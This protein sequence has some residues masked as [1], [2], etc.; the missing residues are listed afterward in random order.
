[1]HKK[2]A[3]FDFHYLFH[4]PGYQFHFFSF[5]YLV[6]CF[7]VFP[8]YVYWG[9][10]YCHINL[11]CLICCSSYFVNKTELYPPFV[12]VGEI[13]SYIVWTRF[14][15]TFLRKTPVPR[16]NMPHVFHCFSLL[17]WFNF[18]FCVFLWHFSFLNFLTVR[19]FF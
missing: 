15:L 8:V 19:R 2:K 13:A 4:L 6:N 10:N 11:L 7:C 17:I 9:S 14:N 16:K 12:Q 18:W 5:N 1:M 3:L